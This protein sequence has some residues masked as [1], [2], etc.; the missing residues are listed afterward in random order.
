MQLSV[1]VIATVG[2]VFLLAEP[3]TPRLIVASSLVLGGISLALL[4]K[5]E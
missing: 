2:G 4:Y 5:K 1:P 3:L